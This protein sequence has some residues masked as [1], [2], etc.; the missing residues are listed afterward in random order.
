M[1]IKILGRFWQ[2]DFEEDKYMTEAL[3]LCHQATNLIQIRASQQPIELA[4]TVIHECLHAAT[5]TLN[6]GY[7][8][9]QIHTTATLLTAVLADNPELRQFI[10]NC[11]EENTNNES[12]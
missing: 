9:E 3:G 10:W 7:T 4:D 11:L 2:I 12:R 6:L 1:K 8:E 5:D